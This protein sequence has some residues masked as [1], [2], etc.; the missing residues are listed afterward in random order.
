MVLYETQLNGKKYQLGT[1]GFL[2]RSNK[3]MYDR[4]TSSMWSTLHGAPVVGPLVGKGIILKRRS[5]VTT[6]WGE[7]KSL[8]PETTVLSLRTGHRRDYGEG[9]AYHNYFN[10]DELM[11]TVPGSDK[12][13]PNKRQVLAFRSDGGGTPTAID[14]EFLKKTPIYS[15]TVGKDKV[16]VVTSPSG[17]ARAYY[18]DDVSFNAW[19]KKETLLDNKKGA[20]KMTE[21]ALIKMGSEKRLQRYP[22]HQSFWFGWH[23]QFPETRLIK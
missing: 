16:V 20:W 22:S 3:L 15:L 7:W 9:V 17:S 19:D 23:A 21:S 11:F 4:A 10:T 5:V 8:H 18:A 2:Y 6:T 12:R 13:L 1:S 14:T